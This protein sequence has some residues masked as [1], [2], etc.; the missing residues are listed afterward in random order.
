MYGD[1]AISMERCKMRHNKH[2]QKKRG[3]LACS[4]V[5]AFLY[6]YVCVCVCMHFCVSVC[7]SM[8]L[9]VYASE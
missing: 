6:V 2:T 3:C 9:Y 1:L 7:I 5:F 8:S 4:D